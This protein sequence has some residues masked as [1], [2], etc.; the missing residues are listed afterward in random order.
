MRA[1]FAP[2]LPRDIATTMPLLLGLL[3]LGLALYAIR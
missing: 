3:S 1:L 2:L